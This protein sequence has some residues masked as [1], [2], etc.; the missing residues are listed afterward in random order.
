VGLAAK[1]D[2]AVLISASRPHGFLLA[3]GLEPELLVS[4]L[5]LPS[6]DAAVQEAS[7]GLGV[8]L[9]KP[10][11]AQMDLHEIHDQ[12][13]QT[14]IRL[15]GARKPKQAALWCVGEGTEVYLAAVMTAHVNKLPIVFVVENATA[16]A[17]EF[18]VCTARPAVLCESSRDAGLACMHVN[19]LD[20]RNVQ[21][22]AE[23][24]L[25]QA[26]DIA[27]PVVLE[28]LTYR[29]QGHAD[30]SGFPS[31]QAQRRDETDPLA[32]ARA[33]IARLGGGIATEARL[34]GLEHSVRARV[35]AALNTARTGSPAS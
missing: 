34:K 1:P 20:V 16:T 10:F 29:Y 14:A 31:R 15:A 33:R 5:L 28:V 11:T 13:S 32:K 2:E 24:A 21:A 26:R 25:G 27:G 3:R 12:L 4:A 7:A 30:A 18:G 9:L 22:A 23:N 17:P 6:L 8:H 19:G 35:S